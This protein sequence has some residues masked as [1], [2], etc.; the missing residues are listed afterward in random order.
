MAA[1]AAGGVTLPHYTVAQYAQVQKVS[2][3]QAQPGD[4]VFWASDPNDFNT[5]YHVALYIGG[6]QVIEAP[7]TGAN[8]QIAPVYSTNLYGYGR[9]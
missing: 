5:I 1:W 3:S 6:G 9:P 7:H 8:V 2:A 4:L